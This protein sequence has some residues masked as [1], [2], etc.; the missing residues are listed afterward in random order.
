M[1]EVSG[2]R[3]VY[4]PMLDWRDGVKVALWCIGMTVRATRVCAKDRND[5]RAPMNM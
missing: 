2:G 1:E 4:S 3:L 5:W